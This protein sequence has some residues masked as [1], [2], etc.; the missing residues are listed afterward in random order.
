MHRDDLCP[1]SLLRRR[2]CGRAGRPVIGRLRTAIAL[3]AALAAS[4]LPACSDDDDKSVDAGLVDAGDTGAD[5]VEDAVDDAPDSSDDVRTDVFDAADATEDAGDDTDADA[6]IDTGENIEPVPGTAVALEPTE[7][8]LERRQEYFDHCL[9]TTDPGEG[10]LNGQMC[11][12]AAGGYALDEEEI[13]GA[14]AHMEAR[15]D[16]SDFRANSLV[17]LLYLDDESGALGESLRERIHTTLFEFKYWL[18]QPGDDGM[19]YWT[20]NHQIL[21]HTAE[22]LMGQ[23]LP[24]T[25]FP[26]SGMTGREHMEHALPRIRRWLDL[27]GRYGFSEWHSNVYFNEDIPAL[28]NLV[29]FAED[30]DIRLGARMVLDV[31]VADLATNMFD[32]TFATTA[33]RTYRSKFIGGSQDSTAEFAWITTGLGTYGSGSNFGATFLATSDYFPPAV[34]EALAAEVAP[35]TEHRQRDSFD[36]SERDEAGVGVEGLDEV[37]VWAGL[38]A[39][40][41][42]DVIDGAMAVNDEYDLWDGFL[43]GS[44]PDSVLNLLRSLMG[45]PQLRALAEELAPLSI[46]IALEGVDTYVYRTP[47]YQLAAAQDW[48]PGMWSAQTL[49]YR[50]AIDEEVSILTTAPAV[51]GAVSPEGVTIDDP[52]IGGWMPRVTAHRNA[53]IIQ[54]HRGDYAPIVDTVV[55]GTFIHAYFPVSLM[56]EWRRSGSW[57]FGRSGDG[58]VGLWSEKTLTQSEEFD[59]EWVVD[60]TTNVFVLELG[61]AAEHGDFD[62]FVAA[63]EAAD[64]TIEADPHGGAQVRF[65]SPS[66]G[67]MEAGWVGPFRVDGAVVD[68]GPYERW[69]SEHVRQARGSRVMDVEVD[70]AWLRLDFRTLERTLYDLD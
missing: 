67:R 53:A 66:L 36:V 27:R 62:S 22:L 60:A 3:T 7:G 35:A 13:D 48:K 30:E 1:G 11:R 25:P 47:D 45:T 69:E 14:I 5:T 23:R 64:V 12:V 31:I 55:Q 38:S 32:G 49:M 17:R 65:D 16:V 33:G 18:D 50:A 4:S 59:Y 39:I 29:D 21:F 9:A 19:A 6:S 28:L 24:D 58:Y 8:F 52:W 37:V 2:R 63:L 42:P 51:L 34:L 40:V 43:F 20:E 41:H 68:I 61:S 57:L 15:L 54:Y 70:D 44:L 46:G 26:N 10:G 56:D